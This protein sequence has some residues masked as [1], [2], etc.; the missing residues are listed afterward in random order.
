MV[1]NGLENWLKEGLKKGYSVDELKSKALEK[2]YS[3]RQVNNA[4]KKIKAKPKPKLEVFLL[5]AVFIIAVV[6]GY[7]LSGKYFVK[8]KIEI[9][10]KETSGRLTVFCNALETGD[11]SLLIADCMQYNPGYD[12][13]ACLDLVYQDLA[14]LANDNSYC[15]KIKT[16][17]GKQNCL[18]MVK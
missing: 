13:E 11:Y 12:E 6:A 10:L 16:D 7:L 4:V 1:N 15:K 8:E 2:G 9:C 14:L 17:L 18:E 3:E 5:I